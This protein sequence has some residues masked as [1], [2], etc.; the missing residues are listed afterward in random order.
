MISII[1]VIYQIPFRPLDPTD[2]HIILA[3]VRLVEVYHWHDDVVIVTYVIIC[4]L[5]FSLGALN[6]V[7][8][9]INKVYT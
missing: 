4:L 1:L 6:H 8:V 7:A 3:K 9:T 5:E 2:L